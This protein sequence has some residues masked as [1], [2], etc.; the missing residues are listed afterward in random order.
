MPITGDSKTYFFSVKKK[1][2]E[3]TDFINKEYYQGDLELRFYSM[4]CPRFDRWTL[5]NIINQKEGYYA[6]LSNIKHVDI[7]DY[8]I[9]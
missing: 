8:L 7:E 5:M 1:W 6:K 9:Y 4:D 3:S 2:L